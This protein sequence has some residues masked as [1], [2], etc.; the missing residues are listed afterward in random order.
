MKSEE[1]RAESLVLRAVSLE[2]FL[3]LSSKLNPK[4]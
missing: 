2:A 4:D 1:L 3:A